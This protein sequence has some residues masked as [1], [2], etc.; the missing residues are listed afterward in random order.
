[1]ESNT[2]EVVVVDLHMPRI[3][4][5]DFCRAICQADSGGSASMVSA[6]AGG[7]GAAIRAGSLSAIPTMAVPA[8]RVKLLL[9]TTAAGSVKSDDLEVCTRSVRATIERK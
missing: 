1:M 2:F 5:M 7:G 6:V 4:G 8:D 9:H 3:N